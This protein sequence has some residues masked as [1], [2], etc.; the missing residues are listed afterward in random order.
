M[1][2]AVRV[3]PLYNISLLPEKDLIMKLE[4]RDTKDD[5]LYFGDANKEWN[6]FMVQRDGLQMEG[7]S[8]GSYH[9]TA[10]GLWCRE[11]G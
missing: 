9:S 6:L 2:L 11:T 10:D 8:A 1:L 3:G 7:L 4:P 5:G